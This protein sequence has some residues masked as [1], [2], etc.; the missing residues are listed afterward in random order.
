[1]IHAEDQAWIIKDWLPRAMAAGLRAAAHKSPVGHFG[2]VSVDNVISG[3]AVKISLQ[4]F[5]SLDEARGW[6]KDVRV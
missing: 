5:E 2:K 3:I 1:M 4:T 6:L